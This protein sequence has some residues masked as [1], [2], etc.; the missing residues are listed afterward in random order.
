MTNKSTHVVPN[1]EKGGWDIK[2]SG[3]ERSSGHF[4][5]K[6]DAVDRARQISKNQETELVIHNR[7]GKI[8][9]KDSHGNDPFPPKG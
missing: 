2:Q 8:S 1:K 5:T 6:Q 9:G 4:D 7:D 3:G